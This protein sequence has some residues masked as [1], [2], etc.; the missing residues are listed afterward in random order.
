MY[1]HSFFW[2]Y[3][4]IAPHALQIAVAALMVK[5][6]LHREFPSFFI[7]TVYQV[8]LNAVLFF[9]DHDASVTGYQYRWAEWIGEIFSIALRFAV[10]HEIVSV[11]FR[12][13]PALQNLGIIAFRWAMAIFG[14]IA[15]AVAAHNP[16]VGYFPYLFA[17]MTLLDRAIAIVQCGTLVFLF[18]FSS[19]FKLS[20]RGYVFGIAIGLGI[21]SATQLATSAV[22]TYL[23][24]YP[25]D[26]FDVVVMGMYHCSVLVWLFYF[27]VAEEPVKQNTRL[28]PVQE[29]ESWNDELRRLLQR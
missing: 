13:Y 19:Y 14:L 27:L 11:I 24:A 12:S 2:Y 25:T 1:P 22:T 6:R 15:V 26:Y 16:G 3:L 21:F 29:L 10:I 20:W 17:G 18:L 4:W 23:G 5:Q 9:L 8:I 7:Y 28:A